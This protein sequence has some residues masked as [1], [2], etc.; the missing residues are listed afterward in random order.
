VG[1]SGCNVTLNQQGE[2]VDPTVE[3]PFGFQGMT[4]L[5]ASFD[6]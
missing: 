4:V 5:T 6:N 3:R 1:A 2:R